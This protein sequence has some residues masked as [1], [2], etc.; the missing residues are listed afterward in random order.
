MNQNQMNKTAYAKPEYYSD[1][2]PIADNARQI[3]A[4]EES[5]VL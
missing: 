2:S 1:D 4:I 5:A 3:K